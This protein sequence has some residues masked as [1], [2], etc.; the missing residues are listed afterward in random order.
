MIGTSEYCC[1]VAAK[2][3]DLRVRP[4]GGMGGLMVLT[5]FPF[6]PEKVLPFNLKPSGEVPGPKPSFHLCHG[7]VQEVPFVRP[8]CPEIGFG[9]K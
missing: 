7:V 1:G 5:A 3:V 6:L 4:A 8:Y 2:G 9:E